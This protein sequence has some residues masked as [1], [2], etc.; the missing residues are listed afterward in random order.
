M[1]RRSPGSTRRRPKPATSSGSASGTACS[2]TAATSRRR[3]AARSR[4][5]TPRP[6]SRSPSSRRRPPPTSTAPSAPRSAPDA[7]RGAEPARPGA[8]QVPVPD[9]PHPP[10]AQPRVRG[11]RVD[12]LGQADQGE[13]RRR[14]AA[15]G[16]ALLVL[17]GLGGQARVRVSRARRA[18][19]RRRRAGHPL[20]LPAAD[21]GLEDRAGARRRQHGRPQARVDDAPVGPPVRR[22]LPPGRPAAG[23][24]QHRPGPGRDRHV[25]RRPTRTSPRSR[26]P[27]RPRSAR[28]ST[29]RSRAPTRRSP[30]SSAARPPT[31]CSRTR[32]STRRSRGSSTG[33]T[34]TRARS[35]ARARGCSS[36]SR[37]PTSWSTGSRT[38]LSTLRV[39]D[40]LDKNTDVGAINSKSQLEKITELV[41]SGVAEGAELYQPACDLPG[42]RLLLPADAVHERRP[43][44]PGREGGDLRAGALGAHVPDARRGGREGEQ[45]GLRPVGRRS[46]PRRRRRCSRW[47]RR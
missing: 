15:R 21:A 5:S 8:R 19:A 25:P 14:R 17:R 32:R 12:G 30:S 18:A 39:G 23:R 28:R 45:H 37:S 1:G 9:R 20:E 36:R 44:P 29:G 35:A 10:G 40:P 13:P 6:S 46:G 33:S 26:S 16:R 11:P 31:S 43:E 24:R 38:R 27:A 2:S 42:A 22:G 41:A 47:S 34:S 4:A 7:A 3:T